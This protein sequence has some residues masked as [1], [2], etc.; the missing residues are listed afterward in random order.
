MTSWVGGYK[1]ICFIR[2]GPGE[3]VG[4]GPPTD[5]AGIAGQSNGDDGWWTFKDT[6][7]WGHAPCRPIRS[8]RS[9]TMPFLFTKKGLKTTLLNPFEFKKQ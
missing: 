8:L 5:V 2:L 4:K 1:P 3:G 6:L 9:P 7:G